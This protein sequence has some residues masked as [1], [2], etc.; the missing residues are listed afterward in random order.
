MRQP[1]AQRRQIPARKLPAQPHQDCDEEF[2]LMTVAGSD[3][4]HVFKGYRNI[5]PTTEPDVDAFIMD[6]AIPRKPHQRIL[7][8]RGGCKDIIDQSKLTQIDRLS[9]VNTEKFIVEM[10]G[11]LVEEFHLTSDRNSNFGLADLCVREPCIL[12]QRINLQPGAQG[13]GIGCSSDPTIC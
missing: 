12:E 6:G 13:T 5:L 11:Q 7:Q 4:T 10:R 8:I 9:E 3:D 1:N 2:D